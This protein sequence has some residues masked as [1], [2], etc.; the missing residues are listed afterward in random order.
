ML[1]KSSFNSVDVILNLFKNLS[2]DK[3]RTCIN[4][5]LSE[6]NSNT[7]IPIPVS[8]SVRSEHRK[9]TTMF[10]G[11]YLQMNNGEEVKVD[12]ESRSSQL[13]YVYTLLHP[14]GFQ[15]RVL[16]KNDYK[17]LANLFCVLFGTAP[18]TFLRSLKHKKSQKEL[19]HFFSHAISRSRAAIKKVMEKAIR[20]S[21]SHQGAW[22][23]MFIDN[24]HH[25]NGRTVIPFAVNQEKIFIDAKLRE[26]V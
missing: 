24:P 5:L 20:Y 21:V 1:R 7:L 11:V 18:D 12:F 6:C 2:E 15:R 9:G 25:N 19:D 23:D 22:N 13:M 4:E 8:I 14:N 10:Y 17:E 26:A 3:Q 16:E